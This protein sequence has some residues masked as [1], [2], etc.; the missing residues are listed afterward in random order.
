MSTDRQD[1]AVSWA[2]R[3]AG[4]LLL[5]VAVLL[6]IA[7]AAGVAL[8]QALEAV[9]RE[10]GKRIRVEEQLD[11]ADDERAALERRVD[12]LAKQVEK[13][14]GTPDAGDPPSSGSSSSSDDTP[15]SSST[16]SDGDDQAADRPAG[17]RRDKPAEEDPERPPRRDDDEGSGSPD[18]EPTPCTVDL[19][20]VKLCPDT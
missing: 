4:W 12:R 7:A 1:T 13:L 15:A 3:I 8:D 19:G 10:R 5:L 6:I 17:D 20:I 11:T 9:D 16:G 18:P 14:G 2:Q